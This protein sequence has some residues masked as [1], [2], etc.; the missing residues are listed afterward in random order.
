[1]LYKVALQGSGGFRDCGARGL[2][3]LRGLCLN[4][5]PLL[6]GGARLNLSE[7]TWSVNHSVFNDHY[8]GK[9][10]IF[11]S[12]YRFCIILHYK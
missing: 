5:V 12:F 4:S 6:F 10:F 8:A 2:F 7:V 9:N 1:M 11:T 3:H